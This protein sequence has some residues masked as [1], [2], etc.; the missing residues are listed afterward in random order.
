[1]CINLFWSFQL[2]YKIDVVLILIS[3]NLVSLFKL[4]NS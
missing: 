3:P 2:F 1:M 4:L